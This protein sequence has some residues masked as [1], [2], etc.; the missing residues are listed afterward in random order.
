MSLIMG[1]DPLRRFTYSITIEDTTA[2]FYFCNRSAVFMTTPFD[3]TKV[4]ILT[5][6]MLIS[7]M[8]VLGP[9]PLDSPYGFVLRS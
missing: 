2:T 8:I 4:N 7:L 1:C 5:N 6:E 3:Y 9:R